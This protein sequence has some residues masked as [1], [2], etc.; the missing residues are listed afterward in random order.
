MVRRYSHSYTTTGE[1]W[2]WD[3]TLGPV[4]LYTNFEGKQ[5]ATK[6]LFYFSQ[7]RP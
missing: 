6:K 3:L 1:E 4:K 7:A 5:L 2:K